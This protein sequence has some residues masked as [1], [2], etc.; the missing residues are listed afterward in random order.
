[1][2]AEGSPRLVP[3]GDI[4]SIIKLGIQLQEKA[5]SH[6]IYNV[7]DDG[8]YKELILLRLFNLWKLSREGHDA[9]DAL[10]RFYEIKT[11]ARVSSSG[12]RKT[13]LQIT[14]EHTLTKANIERYRQAFLW[15]VAAFD[16]SHPE[17]IYEITPMA[18][19]PYF[20]RWE[21]ALDRQEAV[22]AEG[23]ASVHLNNPKIPL[24][25]VAQHGVQV[26]P[27]KDM[28]LPQPVQQALTM[29]EELDDQ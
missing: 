5:S 20:T 3:T 17:A 25:F 10:G 6:H 16:Q 27:P 28:P 7:F 15:I 9:V 2:T 8:G 21:R 22:H 23:G 12:E 14:T 18:L 1:M 29:L 4:R 11:A 26:W 24:N 19:E 13:S